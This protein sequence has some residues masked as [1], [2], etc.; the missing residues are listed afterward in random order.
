MTEKLAIRDLSKSFLNIQ[1]LA[2][3]SFNV[4]RGQLH[5]LVGENG[6]GKSTLIK[7]LAGVERPNSGEIL[8]DGQGYQPRSPV[9]AA[10]R[11]ISTIYQEANLL[12]D[13]DVFSNV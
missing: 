3:V 7:I 8:L 9:E 13:R 2:S 10:A 4:Q 1:A 12:P 6:A 5:A 11:G